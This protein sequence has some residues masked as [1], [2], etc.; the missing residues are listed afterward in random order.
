[1]RSIDYS[2]DWPGYNS[3]VVVLLFD[4][5]LRVCSIEI[6][7]LKLS[8]IFCGKH[9]HMKRKHCSLVDIQRFLLGLRKI[10]RTS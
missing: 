8:N 4:L 2:V 7:Y 10:V 6:R 3:F 9:R 1:M 5:E